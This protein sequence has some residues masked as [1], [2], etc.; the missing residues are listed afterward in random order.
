MGKNLIIVESPT[1]AKTIGKFLGRNYKIMASIGHLRDLP[2]SKMGVDIENDFEPQYINVR[3]KAKTINEIK[4]EAKNADA[5][6]LASDPDREGEAIAWHLAQILN[7]DLNAKNRVV[8]N[9]ITKDAIK[10]AVKNPRKIDLSLVDSQQARRV[11]DRIVGYELSPILWKK[12]KSGL[13]AGRVQSVALKIII[14][15]EEEIKNFIPEEY[16]SI[17]F[18]SEIDNITFEG[19]YFGRYIENKLKS[20]KLKNES[21]AIEI[22]NKIDKDNFVV[23][24][25]VTTKKRRN[26]SK[27]FTTSTLQQEASRKLNF[28]TS[29]TM[30]VAQQLYEGINIGKEGSVG[31][32]SYMRTDSTRLSETIVNQ[33]IDYIKENYGEM[34]ASKGNTYSK[35]SSNAQDAHEAVRCSSIYR[36]PNSIK[37]YLTLDQ[38]KLYRMIW[39]RTVASQMTQ[40]QFLATR[41]DFENNGEIFK[42]SGSIM[43]FDGYTKIWKTQDN[44]IMLPDLKE[45]QVFSI[46][47][48]NKNQHFTKPK[49]RYTEAS[50]VKTLE[51]NGIG[52]PS[53][54]SSIIRS[55]TSRKYV[56]FENK[57]LF[58]TEL[59]YSVNNL[60][61]EYF[62]NIIN[63]KF[64]ASMETELDRIE[65][66]KLEWK[67]LM[68]S[69]YK[70]FKSDL[71]IAKESAEKVEI[72][73]EKVGEKCPDCGN[74]LVYRNG[75]N[76]K[77]I[78]CSNFPECKFTK[79]IIKTTGVSCPKC[80]GEIVEKISKRGKVFYGCKNFPKC[81]YATWDKPT[82]ERCN[83]CGDLMVHR[84]NRKVDKVICANESCENSQ[85]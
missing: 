19:R 25:K 46:K 12:V 51:E 50:L 5:V 69:F 42:A 9:E 32:I 61:V 71:D 40:S 31:L 67:E 47:E 54:Y 85:I 64:T 16:W 44:N 49:H 24:E 68:R 48:I 30:S 72:K 38:F 17:I 83:K 45:G 35:T 15:R 1:K 84:K 43:I 77:F 58:P 55:I 11:M 27:P 66:D 2:K 36:S 62:A 63:E 81:D 70:E 37:E 21:D 4:K 74:D 28:S 65:E 80:G 14:D 75:R 3:G 13:S 52:R 7:L 22:L 76:G 23:K 10:D 57:A 18:N 8:F 33:A 59:G 39:E 20:I 56:E 82:G 26:P 79:A 34:Y 29:K 73:L 78:G 41:Y 6:Y 53:T 60:L